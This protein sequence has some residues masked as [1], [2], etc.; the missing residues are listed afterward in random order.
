MKKA[1]LVA[2][3][4]AGCLG[5]IY[6][7]GYQAQSLGYVLMAPSSGTVN[8]ITNSTAPVATQRWCYNCTTNGGAGT[9][10]YSTS[11][12]NAFSYIL[13]TGTVCK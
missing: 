9:V 6:A 5:A 8:D 11:S 3:L 7:A 1:I 13:S 2:G 12:T 10:C 4:I